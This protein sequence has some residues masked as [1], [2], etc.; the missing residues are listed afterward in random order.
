M[1]YYHS[2]ATQPPWYCST[3]TLLKIHTNTDTFTL[4]SFR[5]QQDLGLK[6]SAWKILF[7]LFLLSYESQLSNE[8]CPQSSS[9]CVA[10]EIRQKLQ[11]KFCDFFHASPFIIL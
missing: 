8:L 6:C 5:Y 4:N 7:V 9:M 11:L 3:N 2:H 1:P 10:R